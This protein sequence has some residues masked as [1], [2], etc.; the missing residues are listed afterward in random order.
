MR[1]PIKI[2][3]ANN[4]ADTVDWIDDGEG[5]FP[6]FDPNYGVDIKDGIYAYYEEL[7]SGFKFYKI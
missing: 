1:Y 5:P 2:L 3:L 7:Q 6:D 4:W